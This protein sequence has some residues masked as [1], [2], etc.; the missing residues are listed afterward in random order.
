MNF[1]HK[2]GFSLIE[3]IISL[4][5]FTLIGFS[6][7]FF[8]K[9]IFSLNRII[10][11][12]LTAQNETEKALKS[13]SAEIRAASPSNIGSYPILVAATS[14]FTIYTNT[15]GDS[16][17]EQVRYFVQ[18]VTLKKG[19]IKPTGNP[20]TYNLANEIISEL[21][22]NV[23]NGSTTA[24]FNYYD[25]NYDG[26]TG[27]LTEP[28]NISAVRLI[29]INVMIDKNPQEPPGPNIFTTQ[30]SIRNLKDNL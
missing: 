10:P 15:D 9:N 21:I 11:N 25:K 7:Y 28:I 30:V 13:M 1:S 23:S 27:P 2:R 20:L 8:Q 4:A 19:V 24:I 14:S 17:K 6:I 3:I 18:G 26:A 5:I 29:K 12:S 22:H 16:L